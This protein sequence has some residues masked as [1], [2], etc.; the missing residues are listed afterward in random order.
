[1]LEILT[2]HEAAVHAL[3][4]SPDGKL[5]ATGSADQTIRLWDVSKLTGR[6]GVER[7]AGTFAVPRSEKGKATDTSPGKAAR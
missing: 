6:S 5:L 7:G 1:L 4:F 2:G 3:A